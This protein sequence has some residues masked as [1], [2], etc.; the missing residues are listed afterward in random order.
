MKPRDPHCL[1]ARRRKGGAHTSTDKRNVVGHASACTRCDGS[2]W[3]RIS[4]PIGGKVSW[5]CYGCNAPDPDEG[6]LAPIPARVD[7]LCG[8]GWGRLGIPESQV[9][10]ECPVC[11]HRF[12]G[13]E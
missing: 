13:E 5:P 11:G 9:P 3:T 2:G 12:M 10:D 1:P 4:S 6:H 7:V 8:C